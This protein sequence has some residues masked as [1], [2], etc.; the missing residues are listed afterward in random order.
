MTVRLLAL[1]S[2]LLVSGCA[3]PTFSAL[4]Q[5]RFVSGCVSSIQPAPYGPPHA[6]A[7]APIG[8]GPYVPN[9]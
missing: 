9:R 8:P 5:C 2:G 4:E 1:V 3:D 7:A 6:Q